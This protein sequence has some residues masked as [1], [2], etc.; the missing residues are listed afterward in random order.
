MGLI[1][2]FSRS[3]AG[4]R[5]AGAR[6]GPSLRER[7]ARRRTEQAEAKLLETEARIHQE[8]DRIRRDPRL[9]A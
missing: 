1:E 2:R 8:A 5:A 3:R 4:R 7:R 6:R 9:S